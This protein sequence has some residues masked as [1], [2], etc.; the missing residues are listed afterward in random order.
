MQAQTANE[1]NLSSQY[2]VVVVDPNDAIPPTVVTGDLSV[3]ASTSG[4]L[5]KAP[6]EMTPIQRYEMMEEELPQL[7]TSS[8][9]SNGAKFSSDS[10]GHAPSSNSS[11]SSRESQFGAQSIITK[12]GPPTSVPWKARTTSETKKVNI[13]LSCDNVRND[14]DNVLCSL[15]LKW[16]RRKNARRTP[17]RANEASDATVDGRD[18][19]NYN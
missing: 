6:R 14:V 2:Q 13:S 18:N 17:R 19:R 1:S 3:N 8:S 11:D 15:R 7:S 12:M 10:N 5:V 4:T 9:S 16:R